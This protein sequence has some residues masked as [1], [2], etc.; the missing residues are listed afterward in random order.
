MK[1]SFQVY[2]KALGKLA[3]NFELTSGKVNLLLDNRPL[4]SIKYYPQS[5]H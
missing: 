1:K 2:K 4:D 5:T 3:L